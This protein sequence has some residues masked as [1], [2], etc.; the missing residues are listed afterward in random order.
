MAGASAGPPVPDTEAM[1]RAAVADLE[2]RLESDSE[3]V[4]AAVRKHLDELYERSRI[5]TFVGIL[6]ERRALNE[7]RSEQAA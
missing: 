7:L 5:K 1:V 2:R 3:R 6:A 4:E